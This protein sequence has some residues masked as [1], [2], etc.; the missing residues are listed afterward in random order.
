MAPSRWLDPRGDWWE[1]DKESANNELLLSRLIKDAHDDMLPKMAE[2][3]Q[4]EGLQDGVDWTAARRLLDKHRGKKT[5]N[6]LV[7]IVAGGL[8]GA[9]RKH[10]TFQD[11][12]RPSPCCKRCSADA[13]ESDFHFCFECADNDQLKE[14]DPEA[15]GADTTLHANRYA[16]Q[17]PCFVTRG[18]IPSELTKVPEP[19]E[20]SYYVTDPALE[21]DSPRFAWDG[22]AQAF[23]DGSGGEHTSDRRLRG[24]GFGLLGGKSERL[25]EHRSLPSGGVG[26]RMSMDGMKAP[27]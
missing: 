7:R 23:S 17:Y 14:R 12:D 2:H 13:E 19:S 11:E 27:G 3:W 22:V 26:R 20:Q 5:F 18:L 1:A 24:C 25:D 15:F 6:L 21:E 8:W 9:Q 4:G 10:Y 16:A